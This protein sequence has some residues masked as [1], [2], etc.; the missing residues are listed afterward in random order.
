MIAAFGHKHADRDRQIYRPCA[1]ALPREADQE[2]MRDFARRPSRIRTSLWSLSKV[3]VFPLGTPSGAPDLA[4]PFA[5][6]GAAPQRD[7][8]EPSK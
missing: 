8:L 5:G 7:Q 4:R 6:D 1:T 3:I 2:T